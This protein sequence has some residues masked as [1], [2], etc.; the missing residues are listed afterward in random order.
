MK[1]RVFIFL[2][3][4]LIF[5]LGTKCDC[6]NKE[7]IELRTFT[8][9]VDSFYEYNESSSTFTL[10]IYN[11]LDKNY[12]VYNSTKYYPVD[13]IVTIYNLALG[14]EVN[15][16]VFSSEATSCEGTLLKKLFISLPYYNN[17]YGSY[18]CIKHENLSVCN[19]KFLS[20]QLTDSLFQRYIINDTVVD[21][22]NNSNKEEKKDDDNHTYDYTLLIRTGLVFFGCF[23]PGIVGKIIIDKIKYKF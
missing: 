11:L 18:E 19:S 20:F 15:I 8:T 1:K 13:G 21:N 17:Y 23:I 3:L 16:K 5:P 6:S 9:Q 12:V 7:L 2:F 4:F 14:A 10:Y 22:K